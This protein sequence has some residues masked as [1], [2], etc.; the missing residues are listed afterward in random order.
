MV[1]APRGISSV[2][3]WISFTLSMGTPK[4]SWTIIEK[5]VS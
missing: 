5:A 2:S 3:D 1:P 4:N